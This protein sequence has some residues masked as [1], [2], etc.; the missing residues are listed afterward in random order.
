LTVAWGLLTIRLGAAWFGHH[1]WSGVW[2]H[3]VVRNWQLH[4]A[5][6]LR[7]MQVA[8]YGPATP[9]TYDLYNHRPSLTALLYV[10]ALGFRCRKWALN[11]AVWTKRRLDFSRTDVL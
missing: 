10:G 11:A 1:D 3:T 7:L 2:V 8:N 5:W 6:N 4:G 9:E